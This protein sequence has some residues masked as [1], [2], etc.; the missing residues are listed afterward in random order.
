MAGVTW[1]ELEPEWSL[2]EGAWSYGG[3]AALVR[4]AILEVQRQG[5]L[6]LS[7]HSP[8]SCQFLW[9]TVTQLWNFS[10]QMQ[11]WE[12]EQAGKRQVAF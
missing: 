11:H 1:P 9:L 12:P 6:Q 10:L 4:D 5:D 2:S 3:H 7:F 8:T